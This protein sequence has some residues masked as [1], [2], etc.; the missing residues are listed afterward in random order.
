[1]YRFY[2]YE[3]AF[4]IQGN[5]KLVRA[6]NTNADL[7]YEWFPGA[8]EIISGSVFYK[9]FVHPIEQTNLGNDVLS[10]DNAE[11]ATVYGAEMELRKRLDF[12]NAAVLRNMTFYVNAALMDGS[13]KFNGQTINSPLQGQSP[14]LVNGGLSYASDN[15]NF[16]VNVLYNRIGE[17]LKFRAAAGAGRNIFEKPRDVLD[18]QVS[19]KLLQ[20]RLELKFTISDI[21][22]QR[23]SWYYKYDANPPKTGYDASSD[24]ILNSYEYG[25]TFRLEI[26]YAFGK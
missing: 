19:Q 20:K 6:K 23:Y 15:D 17:R 25:T 16:S 22:A 4:I 9:Y 5:D 24:R 1:V 11:S 12:F 13:V 10:F 21:L 8:G 14:Y 26:R 18:F 7:R 2:D 3:N